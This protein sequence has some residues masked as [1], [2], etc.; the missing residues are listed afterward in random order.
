MRSSRE[1]Q[2]LPLLT[3]RAILQVHGVP[4]A[5]AL[6]T[7]AELAA[8][9]QIGLRQGRSASAV[10]FLP[11]FNPTQAS[12]I[13]ESFVY[14]YLVYDRGTEATSIKQFY[15]G[16]P[17]PNDALS[18]RAFSLHP[19][20]AEESTTLTATLPMVRT[21]LG[22]NPLGAV[23]FRLGGSVVKDQLTL[24]GVCLPSKGRCKPSERIK[25]SEREH[26]I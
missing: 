19:I 6:S 14:T 8:T 20:R 7:W 22:N 9:Y 24:P 21:A 23:R 5:E 13:R 16:E 26:S 11:Q 25:R 12:A 18:C 15:P 17:I 2:S 4:G 3:A 1:E 10:S